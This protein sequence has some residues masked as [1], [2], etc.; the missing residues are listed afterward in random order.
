MQAFAELR[1]LPAFRGL[2]TTDLALVLEH[3]EW[4][5]VAPGESL[6]EQGEI[7]DAFYAIGSGHVDVVRDGERIADLGPGE[8]FGEV[9]LLT[10][11]PRNATVVAHTP[12]RVFSLDRD[13][14]AGVVAN[15][16][17]RG[18]IDR[19]PDRNMEH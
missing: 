8:H 16:F 11:E 15:T 10:D 2:S 9:A 4:L 3:G 6:I 5:T 13:G 7:G 19:A 14:F 1:A 17:R 12:L 18:P